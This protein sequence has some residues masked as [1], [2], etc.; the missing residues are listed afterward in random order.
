MYVTGIANT[1]ALEYGPGGGGGQT[2]TCGSLGVIT[3]DTTATAWG[4]GNSYRAYTRLDLN[5]YGCDPTGTFDSTVQFNQALVTLPVMTY[6]TFNFGPKTLGNVEQFLGIM[7]AGAGKYSFGNGPPGNKDTADIGSAVTLRGVSQAGTVFAYAGKA[8]CVLATSGHWTQPIAAQGGTFT[9]YFTAGTIYGKGSPTVAPWPCGGVF[10]LTIDGTN[11]QSVTAN[12]AQGF[13]TGGAVGLTLIQGE[14]WHCDVAVKN[15]NNP[16]NG[17]SAGVVYATAPD[18][19]W[20]SPGITTS[21]WN[22]SGRC[23]F[24]IANCD[25]GI[26]FLGKND[27]SSMNDTE[28][29]IRFNQFPGQP[30]VVFDGGCDYYNSKLKISGGM[31][32]QLSIAGIG[33]AHSAQTGSTWSQTNPLIYSTIANLPQYLNGQTINVNG[34]NGILAG[35]GTG[36]TGFLLVPIDSSGNPTT[37]SSLPSNITPGTLGPVFPAG[38]VHWNSRGGSGHPKNWFALNISSAIGSGGCSVQYTDISIKME[39]DLNYIDQHMMIAQTI[40]SG[41]TSG[42]VAISD[43]SGSDASPVG[44]KYPVQ[45]GTPIILQGDTTNTVFWATA[46]ATAGSTS[47]SLATVTPPATTI[48]HDLPVFAHVLAPNTM[49]IDDAGGCKFLLNDGKMLW[50]NLRNGVR[51]GVVLVRHRG[52]IHRNLGHVLRRP[53]LWRSLP[54]TRE[55]RRDSSPSRS[56][57]TTRRRDSLSSPPTDRNTMSTSFPTSIDAFTDPTSGDTMDGVTGG[58]TVYHDVQHSQANDA[59]AAIETAIGT[60]AAPVL[61]PALNPHAVVTGTTATAAAFDFIPCDTTSNA[62]TIT[63]PTTPN[64][65]TRVGVK[66]VTLGGTNAVTIACGGSDVFDKT[67]GSTSATLSLSG[68]SKVWQYKHSTGIWYDIAGDLPLAQTDALYATLASPALTGT[69]TAPTAS[70]GTNTTQIAT[71]AFVL[72][73][74]SGFSSAI[75]TLVNQLNGAT[76][77][78]ASASAVAGEQTVL[79]GSTASQTLTLPAST[80]QVSSPNIIVNNSSVNWTVAAGSGTTMNRFGATGSF[81]LNAGSSVSMILIGTIWYQ[82]QYTLAPPQVFN[83]SGTWLPSGVGNAQFIAFGCG[84]GGGGGTATGTAGGGGGGGGEVVNG[85]PLGNVTASSESITIGTGGGAT[86]SGNPTLVGT[87]GA[88]L[89]LAGGA[90]GASGGGGGN[91]GDG[92]FGPPLASSSP[93]GAG[94]AGGGGTAATKG[95]QGGPGYGRLGSGGG[96]GGGLNTAGG[97]GGGTAGGTGGGGITSAGG[98]GGAGGGGSGTAGN[99]TNIG[100]NGG[101]APANSG[102]GGGGGGSGTTQGTGGTGGSGTV[103]LS[104]DS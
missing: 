48:P 83:A 9:P 87:S 88:L 45:A 69:P 25:I 47:V 17:G 39:S 92:S 60:T 20:T 62:I 51:W 68:Q 96:A 53:D 70:G 95:G 94:S 54:T 2:W 59:I 100:G 42:T 52:V 21:G 28:I 19:T 93:W 4:N 103:T 56:S 24:Y 101:T 73:N 57:R 35:C 98:G 18:N 23:R 99:T 8:S 1:G 29:E 41:F 22:E 67:G 5:D 7:Q 78:S 10:D 86:T 72:A 14:G 61:E 76:T 77:R 84:G 33:F 75:D 82:Y 6:P 27:G 16:V 15:F 80:A 46:L 58:A 37:I 66:I 104:Q 49:Y 79:T 50:L 38:N 30:A 102:C 44:I 36:S 74:A 3:V 12:I 90:H 85:F 81:N 13:V 34:Q 32:P 65:K 11:A 64:D 55:P 40:P 43:T 89:S 63:L 71:T 97:A 26:I 91:G 31:T